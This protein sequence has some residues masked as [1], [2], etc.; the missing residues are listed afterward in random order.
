[1]YTQC[2]LIK[3]NTVYDQ[4]FSFKNKQGAAEFAKKLASGGPGGAPMIDPNVVFEIFMGANRVQE[5]TAFLLEAL[6]VCVL[7]MYC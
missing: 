7:C 4:H 1:M 2:S 5:T 3:H 6:K